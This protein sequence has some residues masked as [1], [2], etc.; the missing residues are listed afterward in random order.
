MSSHQTT[1]KQ[2]FQLHRTRDDHNGCQD[3]VKQSLK[4]VITSGVL[5]LIGLRGLMDG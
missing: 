3:F 2:F 5:R 1:T 4:S